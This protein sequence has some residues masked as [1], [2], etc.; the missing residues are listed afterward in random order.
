VVGRRVPHSPD[1]RPTCRGPM[2]KITRRVPRVAA[3]NVCTPPPR[4]PRRLDFRSTHRRNSIQFDGGAAGLGDRRRS[5]RDGPFNLPR[6]A[7]RAQGLG[8]SRSG[9]FAPRTTPRP[10]G[11]RRHQNDRR[12]QGQEG[13]RRRRHRRFKL[14]GRSAALSPVGRADGSTT[15]QS[16]RRDAGRPSQACGGADR[17]VA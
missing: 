9:A 15:R 8:R 13:V 4:M 14:A 3:A 16:S 5:G 7:T 11:E 10:I 12:P 1:S 6:L 2:S 17:H